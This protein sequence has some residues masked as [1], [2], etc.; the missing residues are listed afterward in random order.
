MMKKPG[1]IIV[2]LFMVVGSMWA[3]PFL[4]VDTGLLFIINGEAAGAPSPYILQGLGVTV[5]LIQEENFFLYAGLLLYGC[6]YQ[7]YVDRAVPADNELADT[8]WT[9]LPQLDIRIGLPIKLSDNLTLGLS[10][11]PALVCPIPLF[12]YDNGE[13]YRARMFEYFYV[14]L[15]FLYGEVEIFLRWAIV[16]GID[17]AIKVRSLYQLA[18]IWDAIGISRLNG[19]QIQGLISLEIKL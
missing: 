9:L 18:A 15:K 5:P 10:L 17:L 13:A 19:L 3:I 2:L 1:L 14:N 16:Q 8:I 4:G 11:G 12:A 6:Q 7:W